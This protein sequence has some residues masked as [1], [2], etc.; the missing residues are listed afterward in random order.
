MPTNDPRQSKAERR[1]AARTKAAELRKQQEAK[2][3]RN[4]VLAISGLGVAV[5]ALVVVVAMILRQGAA[6]EATYS[7]IVYGG[8]SS[9]VVAPVLTD[10]AAPA[11]GDTTNGGVPVSSDGVGTTGDDD[12]V[13]SVYMD[14]MCPYCGEFDRANSADLDAFVE[15]GDV[16]VVYH[17]LSFLDRVSQGTSYSTR[18][19]NASAV[20]ADQAPEQYTAFITAL[21]ANQPE[22]N[23][24][25]LSDEE[26][27]QLALDAGVPQSVVDQFT[28]TVGGTYQTQADADSDPVDHD[29][30]WRTFAPWTSA[31][32]S[33]AGK[34]LGQIQ[35][36]TILI[37][38]VKFEGNSIVNGPLTDAINAAIG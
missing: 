16:T 5:V 38:G 13:V 17:V 34:D 6:N 33:Q 4:R 21:Y 11:G 28:T 22:E 7:D 15:S 20:V 36:P 31:V 2:A 18:A 32:T 9:D 24:E 12:V 3:K 35:T 8:D 14:F 29:G 10:V 27:G 37:D 25:G 26:I 23:T 1:D 30:T 19:A